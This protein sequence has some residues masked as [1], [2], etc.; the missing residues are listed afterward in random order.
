MRIVK[1]SGALT[2]RK[3]VAHSLPTP[4]LMFNIKVQISLGVCLYNPKV[5]PLYL[6]SIELSTCSK[7]E[8]SFPEKETLNMAMRTTYY[9]S[10][11]REGR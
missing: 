8:K 11:Y 2:A 7:K 1:G 9:L 6:I 3:Y 5:S 4:H 10:V